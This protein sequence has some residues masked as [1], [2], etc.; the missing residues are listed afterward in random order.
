[1]FSTLRARLF[2]GFVLVITVVLVIS[3]TSL[4]LF[5]A[6]NNLATRLDLR[7][8]AGKLFERVQLDRANLNNLEDFV[9]Q[10]DGNIGYR[11]IVIGPLGTAIADSRDEDLVGFPVFRNLSS[12]PFPEIYSIKDLDGK[13][14][15][16]TG[17]QL[18]LGF[19][20]IILEP[21]QPLRDL[22]AS[23]ISGELVQALA[24]SGVVAMA[25]ALLLAYLISRSVASP[26]K[27]ISD[28]AIE[29]AQG[30]ESFV[31]PQGP[32]EVRLLGEAFNEMSAQV[33]ASQQSQRDF[34]ANVSH[35]LKTPLTSVQ[36]FAQAILDGTAK[37]PG[38][39]QKAA[40]VIYDESGR[41]Y[42]MVLDLLDLAKLD[43]GTA[44]LRMGEV[45]LDMLLDA[46]VERF[47][48]QSARAEAEI[49]RQGDSLP[50]VT[51]DGDRLAQVFDNLV[52]NALK[53]TPAGGQVQIS[54]EVQDKHVII[55]VQDSGSGIP[56]EE[57]ARIFERF[58]QLDKSRK[59]GPAH[60]V[61][62]GL[63]IAR[64]I[65]QAHG[66]EIGVESV[67]GEGSVFTVRLPVSH[68]APAAQPFPR[69]DK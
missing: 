54:S 53:H 46:V 33:N 56:P 7:N 1:M 45:A 11:T 58:Y 20:L 31:E 68:P 47:G 44:D 67:V 29:L 26:L 63:A 50:Q 10:I 6:R 66:G 57:A 34:V 22:V 14:W 59:G 48:P 42:R 35:E 23:P 24:Q 27:Q 49:I 8:T 60:S 28:A 61:G 62:L 30:G 17:R 55:R 43:A 4:L 36:G 9:Q 52:E 69:R 37:T 40:Q 39:Q 13:V 3:A 19:S 25:I 5:V 64:Q 18:P 12:D 16:Y 21:R 65:V 51:G 15:L 2:S 32:K 41:M 38:A